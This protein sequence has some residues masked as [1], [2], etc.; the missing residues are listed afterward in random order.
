MIFTSR[1]RHGQGMGCIALVLVLLGHLAFL[2]SSKFL[3]L[4]EILEI[5]D[6]QNFLNF[7]NFSEFPYH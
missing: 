3:E 7:Q 6:F 1:M 5:S 2:Q 4:P